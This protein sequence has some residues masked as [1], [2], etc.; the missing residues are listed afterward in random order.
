MFGPGVTELTKANMASG[1][2]KADVSGRKDMATGKRG[3]MQLCY[4]FKSV[5]YRYTLSGHF[6]NWPAFMT[7]T[8][9]PS[10]D[11]ALP[12]HVSAATWGWQPVRTGSASLVEQLVEHFGNRIRNHGL[13]AGMR[14]RVKHSSRLTV[15]YYVPSV[16][17]EYIPGAG[18][19]TTAQVERGNGFILS[20]GIDQA[21]DLARRDL[22]G[23]K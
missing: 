14:L 11:I 20:A 17:Q 23:V 9:S 1:R 21:P 7:Q 22:G 18:F 15:T 16:S 12:A 8:L 2:T 13:R 4:L 3:D 5:Q 19:F 6:K 10:A